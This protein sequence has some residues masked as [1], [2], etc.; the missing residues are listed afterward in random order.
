MMF[1]IVFLKKYRYEAILIVS[2]LFGSMILRTLVTSHYESEKLEKIR[3]LR[4]NHEQNLIQ[5]RTGINVYS[6][7]VSSL[8]AHVN[9]STEF[10]DQ[11]EMQ[12]YLKDLIDQIDFSD[13]I[14]VSYLDTNHVFQYVVTPDQ[15]DP[16]NLTGKQ[17]FEFRPTSERN[18]L[19]SLLRTDKI[20]LFR[21]VN[22]MEGWSGFPFNFSVKDKNGRI[23]GYIAPVINTKY[24]LNCAIKRKTDS[25]FASRFFTDD[26][27]DFTRE[28]VYDGTTIYNVNRDSQYYKRLNVS[29][30]SFIYSDLSFFGL[31]LS[32]GSAYINEP[33]EDFRVA[34]LTYFW[35]ISICI[36][37]IVVFIQIYRI[38]RLNNTIL[39]AKSVIEAKNVSLEQNVEKIQT[40]IKEVHHRVKN[41]MQIISSLLNLQR[42]DTRNKEIRTALEESKRRIQSM[43]LVHQKLYEANDLTLLDADS[44]MSQLIEHI[45]DS[46]SEIENKPKK[47]INIPAEITFDMDVMTPLGLI[48]NELLT[49]SYKY[50]F[51]DRKGSIEL[52]IRELD[53]KIELTY[54]DDGPG[55][56]ESVNF[57]EATTLGLQLINVLVDQLDGQIFYSNDDGSTFIIIFPHKKVKT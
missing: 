28:A 56:P 16:A 24:L 5:I 1:L 55:L 11:Y 20:I 10:P 7:I 14:V 49:N 41:N 50:A 30:R 6:T 26:S 42:N 34:F 19:D 44:Y 46:F 25:L 33:Q 52:S 39:V 35:F 38:K 27:V 23:M 21:P 3:L 37:C 57:V 48:L 54:T 43:S 51:K 31:K 8:R 32:F 17:L 9:N 4:E 2:L 18:R 47:K 36:F 45:E 29:K 13:S 12:K 40:L 53:N 22:L 15:I